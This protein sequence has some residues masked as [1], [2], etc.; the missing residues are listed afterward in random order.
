MFY[1]HLVMSLLDWARQHDMSRATA[2]RRYHEGT[3]PVP[4]RRTETGRIVVDVHAKDCRGACLTDV[5]V[6]CLTDAVLAEL[7]R[8]GLRLLDP[9]QSREHNDR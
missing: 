3:L 8:R 6:E 4:A 2:Y 9:Q 7:A 5:H 1:D